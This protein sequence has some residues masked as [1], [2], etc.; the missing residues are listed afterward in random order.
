MER[1][2]QILN[3]E[4]QSGERSALL[5]A[6][7]SAIEADDVDAAKKAFSDLQWSHQASQ[8]FK[9]ADSAMKAYAER[10]KADP[11]CTVAMGTINCSR[12]SNP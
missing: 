12:K 7:N 9:D 2:G 11:A 3:A 5:A 10:K 1:V 4:D 6:L 8:E